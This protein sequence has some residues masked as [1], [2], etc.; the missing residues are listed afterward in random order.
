MEIRIHRINGNKFTIHPTKDVMPALTNFIFAD[1]S[2]ELSQI[3][4]YSDVSITTGSA[5]NIESQETTHFGYLECVINQG[6]IDELI[7]KIGNN[8]NLRILKHSE[9]NWTLKN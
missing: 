2:Y 8:F 1:Q 6:T 4:P 7:E 3:E 9:N 5:F